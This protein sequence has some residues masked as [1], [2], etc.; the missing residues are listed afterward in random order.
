MAQ[1][2]YKIP[3]TNI[4]IKKDCGVIIPIYAIQHDPQ[5]YNN[6]EIYDPDRFEPAEVKKR[7][8]MT[9]LPFGHGPRNCIGYRFAL[10]QVRIAIILV[11][12]QFQVSPCSKTPEKIVYGRAVNLLRPICDIHL[13]MDFIE[14]Q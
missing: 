1:R 5:Y 2:D 12:S 8:S 9:F 3:D 7:H 4:T 10:M 14:N 13:K 6:P 11:L